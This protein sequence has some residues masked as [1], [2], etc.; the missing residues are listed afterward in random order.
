MVEEGTLARMQST[1]KAALS[2]GRL[3]NPGDGHLN[4]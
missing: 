3:L 4:G 2:P 1:A